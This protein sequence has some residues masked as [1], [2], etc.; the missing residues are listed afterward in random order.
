MYKQFPTFPIFESVGIIRAVLIMKKQT[1]SQKAV[2]SGRHK[3]HHDRWTELDE[4]VFTRINA[5]VSKLP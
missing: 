1:E 2:R 5:L 4:Y 3:R